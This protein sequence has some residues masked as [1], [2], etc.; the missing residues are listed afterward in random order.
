LGNDTRSDT[1]ME[2]NFYEGANTDV[3]HALIWDGIREWLRERGQSP[4]FCVSGHRG[5]WEALWVSGGIKSTEEF[6]SEAS[7]SRSDWG[8]RPQTPQMRIDQIPSEFDRF[9]SENDLGSLS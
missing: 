6:L 8:H 9:A 7:A 1:G 4:Y 2:R 5:S 3:S